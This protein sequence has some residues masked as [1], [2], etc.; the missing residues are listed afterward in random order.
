[1]YFLSASK[2]TFLPIRCIAVSFIFFLTFLLVSEVYSQGRDRSKYRTTGDTTGIVIDTTTISDTLITHETIDSTARIKYFTY[3]RK[4]R[5]IPMFGEFQ[6][7]LL[8]YR[9][10]NIEYKVTFDSADNVQISELFNGEQIKVPVTLPFDEYIKRVTEISQQ[11]QF[12]KI[13]ADFYKISTED[14]LEKLFKSITDISIPLPFTSETIFGPPTINLKINGVIDITGSY[15]KTTSDQPT[16]LLESQTQTNINFKQEVQVTTKGSVGDKLTIDADWNSQRTFEFENQL[17]LKYTGYPDEVVQSIEAG[18]VSLET[19]SNLI[20]STQALFGVKAQLKLG[21]LSLTGIASQKKSERKEVNITGGTQ[22]TPFEKHLWDYSENHYFVD[23]NYRAVFE[24]VYLN[25]IASD[26][27][28]IQDIEVWAQT[29]VTNP[30]KRRVVAT[31]QLYQR[32]DSGYVDS[33]RI[34]DEAPGRRFSGFFYKL[35]PSEYTV[36]NEAGYISINVTTSSFLQGQD[37]IAVA[38]R[39]KN[40]SG[41]YIQYGDFL[42]NVPN[43][44][45]LVLKVARYRNLQPPTQNPAHQ[46]AWQLQLRNIYPVDARNLR[47]DP[48]SLQFDIFYAY[49]GG[50]PINRYAADTLNKSYLNMTGLDKFSGAVV[51][52]T[53]PGPDGLI[54]FFPNR[55]IDL[56]SGEVI[57]PTLRPF[58]K[59]LNEQGVPW[60]SVRIIDSTLYNGSKLDAQNSQLRFVLKGKA[61]GE[62]SSRYNLGFNVVEGSVKVFSGSS[63]LT[64]GVDYTVD[65]TSGELVIRNAAAL[66]PGANLKI[67]YETNDLFTLASKTLLGT[68][69]E[70]TLNKTSYIG[71][72]LLNLKQQTLNDKVRIG[73]EPTNNTIIGFDGST[74][75]KTNFLTKLLN[76]IPGYNTKEESSL[77]L[78]GEIAFM[79]PDPNTKKS[80]IPSD[81]GEAVAYIDDFEGAK[82]IV[83]LGTSP[84]AWIVGSIPLDSQ[85]VP[86]YLDPNER[87]SLMSMRRCKM[88]WYSLINSVPIKDVY[89]QKQIPSNQNQNLTP[90][91]IDIKPRNAGMFNYITDEIFNNSFSTEGKWCGIF[92]YLNTT[93]TNL[94]DEN[95]N[96]IE[97]WMKIE[98]TPGDSARMIIDLGTITEKIITSKRFPPRKDKN[99][100]L[101]YHTEDLNLNGTLDEGEDVGLDGYASYVHTGS[102]DGTKELDSA[103]GLNL[104]SDPSRDDFNWT[105]GSEIF[106][107]FNG[108]EGNASLSEGRRIDTEDLNGNGTLDVTNS[109]YEYEIP[110]KAD[111]TNPF[112]YGGGNK[113]WFQYL[114]PL[115]QFKRN[116]GS[117]TFTQI[118]YARIWFKG[119]S[120][121]GTTQIRIVDMS[122]TGNQWVK[123]NKN[124]TSYT[125]SVVNI[126][127]NSEIYQPPVP[128][129]V[130]RQRDQTQA[131]QNI[132][133]NEQ[134]LS[135]ELKNILPGQGKFIFKTFNT[136]PVDLVNYRIV[137]MFVNGDPGFKYTDTSRYDAA[138]VVRL[139][140]DTA[141][142]YE[143]RAPIHPDVRPG[144]PWDA[145]NEVVINLAEMTAIKQIRDSIGVKEYIPVPN[146][147]PGS[148]Y[149]IIGNP[150]I[151]A[152]TQ[153]VLGVVNNKNDIQ[154]TET[155][156]GSVWFN[157][158][159]VLKT[160]NKSGYAYTINAGLKVADFANLNFAYSKA[161][162]NFH[163]LEGRFG[164][165]NL[166]NSWEISGTINAH[167]LINSMLASFVSLKLKDFL[168]LPITFSHSEV[169]DRP[170]YIPGTDVDLETAVRN[171]DPRAANQ[172]R[173]ASQT[174]T[175][176]NAFSVN[177]MKLTFPSENFFVKELVNKIEISFY[178]NSI[179]ERSPLIEAKYAWDMGGNIGL[180]SA[181]PLAEKLHLNI[182]KLIPL[183]EEFKEARL[184]FFFPFIPLTP[185]FTPNISLGTNFTR[186]RGDEKLRAL[187][188]NNPTTRNFN[189]NRNFSLDWKFIEN[190][191]IDVTGNYSFSA[192]SDLTYLEV[193]AD[194]LQR[195]SSQILKDIFFNRRLIDFGK[196]LTY[197]QVVTVN[198]KFNIPGL[199]NFLDITSSYRVQYGWSTAPLNPVL[200][201]N[202]GYSADLQASAF[203]KIN[204]IVNLFKPQGFNGIRAG[205]GQQNDTV[206]QNF[207]DILKLL[208]TFIPGQVNLTYSRSNTV[209]NPG[210]GG[211]PGFANFWMFWNTKQDYGPSRL[212]QLGLTTDPGPRVPNVNLTDG[213]NENNNITVST[214]INPIF[215]DN[216][217]I[218]FSFKRGW[219]R[220]RT[221]TY[222]TDGFGNL[223]SPT[224]SLEIKTITRP[225]FFISGEIIEKLAKPVRDTTLTL[226]QQTLRDADEIANSFENDF[227]SFPF[228]TWNLTLSGVEKF[229]LFQG[230]ANSVSIESGYS[231]EYRKI[232]KISP[233]S[234][235][236]IQ[237]QGITTGFTPLVGINISFKPIEGGNL[238]ASFKLNKANNYELIPNSAT[239]SN[240]ATS[241]MSIN[242]SYS[243]TG[244]TIPL[245]GLSLSNDLTIAFSYT[246]T[247]NDPKQIKYNNLIG[248]WE[249]SSLNGSISTTIN[250]S[251]QYALSKSVT[252]QLFYK[253]NKTGPSEGSQQIPTRTNNEA[254][255][256]LKLAIQ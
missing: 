192:G 214:F 53:S 50:I 255:L 79:L 59:T 193:G 175:I 128:G 220:D 34:L 200:G 168:T 201:N 81:N 148:K 88:N 204:Q 169:F 3:Q 206:K 46:T 234:P 10:S 76:K 129:D 52:P 54:D 254:G 75:I 23:T 36:H 125:V 205:S 173:I 126:E 182:G 99:R 67:T 180:S 62:S 92:K 110:L 219:S 80:R 226:D 229:E 127:D 145:F 248:T 151:R 115:D 111:S 238:T 253:Y 91:V 149:G 121:T 208:G 2:H 70:L 189:A 156:S 256:N 19:K 198:P 199:R 150:S 113:G 197:G 178:R 101:D 134:S 181:L 218:S 211:R 116:V 86:N 196:D 147:P 225:S 41:Q 102:T 202:V 217:K 190:W 43:D 68:R 12:Y 45:T 164:N 136:R 42:N 142:Y 131:D 71:F 224:N 243:K 57:F 161:D 195:A 188:V 8:L 16:I 251:I 60:D 65:Y 152:I 185:L 157:E 123:S 162:P 21:P 239:I 183:G 90:L 203:L 163:S 133:L 20:G 95:I 242:T 64:G 244:F 135:L 18:N 154:Y 58:S 228:P 249:T 158:L 98:N 240:T 212:Y 77:S 146:G 222:V 108:T 138:M 38:Y 246:R 4:D 83:P 232:T 187:L 119:I 44:A 245:F 85:L 30:N 29:V 100:D 33:L 237:S 28:K 15:Q 96:F 7:P 32:P 140:T 130:L 233:G 176:R 155:I 84:L 48:A 223:G 112:I 215:P 171:L 56:T 174:L 66:A 72:T 1:L 216:L 252:V 124:D 73:E 105:Q 141:N 107:G 170:L 40:A 17:K 106:D 63:E 213:N 194:S 247:I 82:K 24:T 250:P 25:G 5:F 104:G 74:D 230:F 94:V 78:K 22:E 221:W 31:V 122:L 35:S 186:G 159:R 167:K 139:G 166:A 235:D 172:L 26:T 160:N 210:V 207:A 49:P 177:G 236:Y 153:I 144:S 37:G 209:A 137:K 97:I 6:H 132:F 93:T 109:Y 184:Y 9:S 118:Q 179:T 241:D 117:A 27:A 39:T 61:V 120:D 69:A 14:E 89:P 87:D 11:Q 103:Q 13:V 114:I 227:V 55:T 47:Y 231:S 165:L 143:Y 191:M 51:N